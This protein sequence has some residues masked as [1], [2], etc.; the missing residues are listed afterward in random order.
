MKN[1]L[2]KEF[3]LVLHPGFYLV[4]LTAA[5]LIIPSWI[6]FVAMS[7]IYFIAISNLFGLSKTNNDT[8]FSI[9]MPVKKTDVV[10]AR[11]ISICFLE[12]L[13]VVAAIPFAII[14]FMLYKGNNALMDPNLAF[15]GLVLI[16]YGIF[17]FMFF[18]SFYKTGYKLAWPLI[19]AMIIA[20]LFSAVVELLVFNIP[21]LHEALDSINPDMLIWKFLTLLA[22]IIIFVISNIFAFKLSAKRF[23]RLEF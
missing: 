9:M 21:F 1:L 17:N 16:M 8:A 19:K 11:I 3:K 5:L 22:G 13:N 20:V 7:Y 15:F 2:Y 23:E 6:Y 18:P 10:K 12:L 14:N 4:I